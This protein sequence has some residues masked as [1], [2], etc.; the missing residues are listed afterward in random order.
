LLLRLTRNLADS[1]E[2][3]AVGRGLTGNVTAE[4]DLAVGDLADLVRRLPG[5]AEHLRNQDVEGALAHAKEL[6]DGAEFV[7]A[8]ERFMARYGMRGPSEIDFSRPGWSEAPASLIQVILANLQHEQP[9][10]HRAKHA[11]LA[12]AGEAAGAHL[13]EAA[14]RGPFGRVRAAI[15]RRLVRVERNLMATREHPKYLLIRLRGLVRPIL[16]D[17]GVKLAQQGR[18]GAAEDIW[19]LTLPEL[20]AA[21][22]HPDE[23]LCSRMAER[24]AEFA[25]FWH[26][27]A[28]RVITSDGE[29][30]SAHH[31][32]DDLPAGALAGIPVSAGIVEGT[33]RVLLDPQREQLY[34][35]E[36]LVA[37]FTDPGWTPLFINAAGLV[38]EVGGLMT[39]GSVVAREY[40]IPAVVSVLDATRKIKSGQR[41][42]VHGNEGYVEILNGKDEPQ[43]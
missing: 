17:L 31:S 26:I 18:I 14:R 13:A 43:P 11:Q 6:A 42:R 40:G 36:I 7:A 12:Q 10:A 9:G 23:E 19:F 3:E 37:P 15:V 32:T 34:P 29:I 33:A 1:A 5:V 2:V 8:W 30:P 39:H 25:R 28:P 4:M 38:M 27:T 16:L 35:G 24:T 22:E 41:I 21:L 20:I